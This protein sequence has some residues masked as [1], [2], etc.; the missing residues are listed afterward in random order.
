MGDFICMP[1]KVKQCAFQLVDSLILFNIWTACQNQF[2]E[3][4][5]NKQCDVF[6][7]IHLKAF[8]NTI[9]NDIY[10]GI[11]IK[12]SLNYH[13]QFVRQFIH[14]LHFHATNWLKH[15]E[16]D[17]MRWGKGV[18]RFKAIELIKISI[19]ITF[20]CNVLAWNQLG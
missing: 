2:N 14:S 8:H 10:L 1:W 18:R 15:T 7:S 9:I 3:I 13:T 20:N 4:V 19:F 5:S 12:A 6:N 11:H 17:W 16:T